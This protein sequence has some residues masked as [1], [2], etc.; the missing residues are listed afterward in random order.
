MAKKG[1]F[2]LTDISGYTEFLTKSELDHA[3]DALQNLFDVQLAQI[4]HPFVISGFRGDAIFLYV[5]E[6]NFC[7]PQALLESLENLYF[8]FA[9]A[10]RQMIYNTTCTCRACQ[11]MSKLDLK[12]VIHYGEYV[13]QKLGDREELLGADVI[14]PRKQNCCGA[15]HHHNGVEHPAQNLARRNIDI[16]LRDDIDYIAT[17]IAGCG[18]MLREYDLL[19]RDDPNYATKAKV[20]SSKVRDISEVLVKLGLPEMKH[21]LD[22]TITYHDACH[23]AHAQKVTEP[24]RQLLSQI[25]GL[26][27]IPLPEC[28]MC[29]GAAGTYNLTQPEMATQLAERKLNNIAYTRTDICATGNVGCALHIQSQAAS[30]GENLMVVHPI[31]L[32]HRAVFGV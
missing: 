6:T 18:A 11:N 7:E 24:P 4:K 19:L 26:K 5:P 3:Q 29:C 25:P 21:P 16:F 12:M 22:I 10:L 13:I 27:L 23:L 20:F 2:I 30:R 8:V 31:E 9:D 17:D 15:I 14:V 32:L 28:D 1:Y